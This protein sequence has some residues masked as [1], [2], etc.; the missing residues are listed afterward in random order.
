MNY[1]ENEP[2]RNRASE[3]GRNNDPNLMDDSS[4]QPGL[5]PVSSRN[6]DESEEDVT[7]TASND[8]SEEE[9]DEDADAD[10]EDEDEKD[11]E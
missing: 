4:Q 3:E 9:L 8:L 2:T 11:E 1:N 7:E 10:F 6:S 5:Q